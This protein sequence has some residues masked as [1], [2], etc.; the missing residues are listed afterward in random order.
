MSLRP[1]ML[2]ALERGVDI[3]RGGHEIIPTWHVV[4]G[5]ETYLLLTRFDPSNPGQ[6]DRMVY[7]V[8]RYMHWKMATGFVLCAEIILGRG[9][10]AVA[11]V[12]VSSTERMGVIRRIKRD[13]ATHFGP[14][15]WLGAESLD[16]AYFTLLPKREEV[17]SAEEIAE[18]SLIFGEDGEVPVKRLH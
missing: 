18:L 11:S 12:A 15:E 13:A 9:V 16:T 2:D 6:R 7:L 3:V 10:D 17:L 8:G 5:A 4:C 1:L 14:R